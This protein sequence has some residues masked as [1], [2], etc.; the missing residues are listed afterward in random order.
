MPP[1]LRREIALVKVEFP[2]A[3]KFG[4]TCKSGVSAGSVVETQPVDRF[5]LGE[6][7]QMFVG[8]FLAVQYKKANWKAA[9]RVDL[10]EAG[11]FEIHAADP[12]ISLGKVVRA[13]NIY[14]RRR[15]IDADGDSPLTL[16]DEFNDFVQR[17]G[18]RR[19]RA[20]DI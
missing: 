15:F 19:S 3:W 11:F 5:R 12:D 6:G 1:S 13:L 10:V 20:W 14:P 2:Q 18:A 17:N 8:E 16:Q 4:K 9:D 7:I